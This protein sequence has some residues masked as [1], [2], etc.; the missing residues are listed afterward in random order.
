MCM[1][2]CGSNMLLLLPVTV[3]SGAVSRT[4]IGPTQHKAHSRQKDRLLTTYPDHLS[5]LW[6]PS[7]L[8]AWLWFPVSCPVVT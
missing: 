6:P 5:L 2:K 7:Y 3:A 8:T 4:A 1:E